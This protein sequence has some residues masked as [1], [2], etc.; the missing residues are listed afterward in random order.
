MAKPVRRVNVLEVKFWNQLTTFALLANIFLSPIW[1]KTTQKKTEPAAATAQAM[2]FNP[3]LIKSLVDFA[4]KLT[5]DGCSL[6]RLETF[7]S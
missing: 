5:M 1:S 6:K 3:V 2:D 7:A 4:Q